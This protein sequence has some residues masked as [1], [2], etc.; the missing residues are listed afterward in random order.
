L[1]DFIAFVDL[2]DAANGIGAFAGLGTT[3]PE[4]STVML[5][6]VVVTFWRLS[7]WS[8]AVVNRNVDG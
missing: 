8:F 2:Y 6:G 5:L 3:V 7:S 4:P 1:E